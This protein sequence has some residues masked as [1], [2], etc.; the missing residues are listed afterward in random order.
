MISESVDIVKVA[1]HLG[2]SKPKTTLNYYAHLIPNDH[3]EVANIFHNAL[4]QKKE[5]D[6]SFM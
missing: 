6:V 1:N 3:D 2:H 4:M 5:P